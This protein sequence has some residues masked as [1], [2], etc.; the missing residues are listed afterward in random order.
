MFETINQARD[1]IRKLSDVQLAQL[2]DL[3]I[4]E[5]AM[6]NVSDQHAEFVAALIV[7]ST[8]ERIAALLEKESGVT[9]N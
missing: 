2:N 1:E 8:L 5:W 7:E 3:L 4:I 9:V 6:G